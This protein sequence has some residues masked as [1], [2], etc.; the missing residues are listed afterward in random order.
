VRENASQL[1]NLAAD[2]NFDQQPR[3]A[4]SLNPSPPPGPAST[5]GG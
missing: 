4:M 5:V 2:F 3:L 1:G